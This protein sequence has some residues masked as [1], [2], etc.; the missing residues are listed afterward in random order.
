M[1][2][3]SSPLTQVILG[4]LTPL[5]QAAGLT[6]T[7]LARQAAQEAIEACPPGP[8]VTTAQTVAFALAALD[9]LRLAAPPDVALT[10][11]LRLRGNANA[12]NRSSQRAA[13]T[14]ASRPPASKPHPQPPTPDRPPSDHSVALAWADAMTD[15]AAECARDLAKLPPKQRRAEIIRINALNAT[16]RQIRDEGKIPRQ[17]AAPPPQTPQPKSADASAETRS[18]PIFSSNNPPAPG[19]GAQTARKSGHG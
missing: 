17:P 9:N 5:M 6:D 15:V 19:P 1:T 3:Q 11:K 4:F 12:L 8:L 13:A 16:A 10:T 7:D 18:R 14:P 2:G